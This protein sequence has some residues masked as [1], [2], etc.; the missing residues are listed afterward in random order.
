[1]TL[2][3]HDPHATDARETRPQLIGSESTVT[4]TF[5][6]TKFSFLAFLRE[7]FAAPVPLVT[8]DLSG[9]IVMITGSNTGIGFEAARH[10]ASMNP[11]RLI[12]ACRNEIRGKKAVEGKLHDAVAC[13][14]EIQHGR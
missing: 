7:Q 5:T 4:Q 2:V 11:E 14:G 3:Q 1:M 8:T 6:M 12:L 13:E 10:F 9:K